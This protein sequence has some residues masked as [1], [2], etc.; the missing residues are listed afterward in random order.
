M[1]G[2]TA[3]QD[4]TDSRNRTAA[5]RVPPQVIRYELPLKVAKSVLGF[6]RLRQSCAGKTVPQPSKARVRAASDALRF[7]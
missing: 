3:H 1:V 6:R 2:K 7:G 4:R 5:D